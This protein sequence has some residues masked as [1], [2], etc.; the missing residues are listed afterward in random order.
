MGMAACGII[1]AG[2]DGSK[3]TYGTSVG[4]LLSCECALAMAD[5]TSK[6]GGW[7][8]DQMDGRRLEY[9]ERQGPARGDW[10]MIVLV[11][12]DFIFFV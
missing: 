2:T 7:Q 11:L 6:N 3:G 5:C 1:Q 8:M 4:S 10:S 12:V 9:V